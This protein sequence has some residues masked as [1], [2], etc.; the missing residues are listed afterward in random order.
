MIFWLLIL[1]GYISFSIRIGSYLHPASYAEKIGEPKIS[2][3]ALS[4]SF[5]SRTMQFL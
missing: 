3:C 5:H 1:M 2:S 4:G